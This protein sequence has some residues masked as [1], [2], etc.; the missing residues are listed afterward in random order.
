M[1]GRLMGVS[2]FSDT[3][4]PKYTN[5]IAIFKKGTIHLDR[6]SMTARGETF[7]YTN[8][9]MRVTSFRQSIPKRPLLEFIYD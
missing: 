4:S 1:Y 5:K 3:D 8:S 7:N 2:Q 6:I 9:Y